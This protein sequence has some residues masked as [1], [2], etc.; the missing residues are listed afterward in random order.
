MAF[1][2]RRLQEMMDD[3][4]GAGLR[5][6]QRQERVRKEF[7]K[8]PENPYNQVNATFNSTQDELR[9]AAQGM[10]D[11]LESRLASP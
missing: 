11:D 2:K 3:G 9:E 8:S 1:E 4:S 10:R 5:L 6:K 7:E